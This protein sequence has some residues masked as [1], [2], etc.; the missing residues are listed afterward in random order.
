MQEEAE[1]NRKV[2]QEEAS[3]RRGG[4][5]SRG[6]RG[7]GYGQRDAAGGRGG[8]GRGSRGNAGRIGGYAAKND[9]EGEDMRTHDSNAEFETKDDDVY[10]SAPR[11]AQSNH[12]QNQGQA[13]YA[14]NDDD[15]E[16]L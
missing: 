12:K 5:G 2:A 8:R 7:G 14:F 6:G 16:A 15:F 10:K 3:T 4:R 9:D 11:T 13:K 1:E